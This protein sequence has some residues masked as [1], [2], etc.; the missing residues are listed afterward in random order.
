[1]V[2][3]VVVVDRVVRPLDRV[4]RLEPLADV[5][6]DVAIVIRS[7]MKRF[8]DVRLTDVALVDDECGRL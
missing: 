4:A 1:M 5:G 3:E 6:L 8:A 7:N 2:G